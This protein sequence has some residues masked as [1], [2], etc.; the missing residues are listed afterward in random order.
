MSPNP[1][2]RE[3]QKTETLVLKI[4]LFFSVTMHV[5]I[6]LISPAD[7]A[8]PRPTTPAEF[9]IEAGLVMEE[10]P[11]LNHTKDP[12]IPEAMDPKQAKKM[13]PQLPKRVQIRD[14]AN[15]TEE[16]AFDPSETAKQAS[17]DTQ[18]KMVTTK[19]AESLTQD[20]EAAEYYKDEIFK[21]LEKE[22]RRQ[23]H[24]EKKE[25]KK[26]KKDA[27]ITRQLLSKRK[28]ELKER[29]SANAEHP[30]VRELQQSI[31]ARY[32]PPAIYQNPA[33][34][35]TVILLQ[36]GRNGAIESLRMIHSSNNVA[37]DRFAE[38]SLNDMSPFPSPP[39][40][41]WGQAFQIHLGRRM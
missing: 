38:K 36:I 1:F 25:E 29:S 19:A 10:L 17:E 24:K 18:K 13:L 12:E 21:R 34:G 5:A 33:Y 16:G 3:S 6:L 7:W 2:H 9:A 41:L 39:R 37:L 40:E 11:I 26:R 23:Q 4:F 8:I 28:Q 20:Q 35:Q 14:S 31:N 15:S 30:Y 22:L 32:I 27:K